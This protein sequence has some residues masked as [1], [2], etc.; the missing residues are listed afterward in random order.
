MQIRSVPRLLRMDSTGTVGAEDLMGVAVC[1]SLAEEKWR[2]VLE[3]RECSRGV[4]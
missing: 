3:E 4:G 2:F 1:E